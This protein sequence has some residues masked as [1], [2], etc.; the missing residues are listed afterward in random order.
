MPLG[1]SKYYQTL[2]VEP[3]ASAEEIK[4]AYR[5]LAKK[6]HPDMN[7]GNPSAEARFK[8]VSAAYEVLSDPEKR[9]L[10]DEFGEDSTRVGFDA[11]QAREWSRWQQAS[12]GPFGGRA[13]G[14]APGGFDPFE[15]GDLDDI[16]GGIFGGR[17]NLGGRGRQPRGPR[18]GGDIQT[19]MPVDFRTAALGGE[20]DLHFA[21][22]RTIKV[23]FPPAVEDGGT[24][25]VRGQGHPGGQGG[26]PGD[27]L[28]KVEV[29]PHPVFRRD[30]L[31]LLVTLPVT[32]G[33]A[34]RGTSVRVPTLEGEVS[35][36][37]PAGSQNGRRL[38]VRGKGLARKGGEAGDLYVTL[39]VR[40]P[41]LDA[42]ALAGLGGAIDAL[43]AT[44]EANPRVGWGE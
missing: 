9:K 38:R 24:I 34:L 8:E 7:K 2:G 30:G 1:S 32:V 44:Y 3:S 37:V 28:I 31:D 4:K 21:D 19:E 43:E 27:L 41:A 18:K 12:G 20:R 26:P 5:K 25:R 15:G 36:K 16:F 39:D 29:Q 22:G 10:Y 42:E 13:P 11:N 14:G 35:L 6:Y 33:E 17:V 23:R 40:L